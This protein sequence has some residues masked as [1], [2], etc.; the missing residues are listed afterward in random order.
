MFNSRSLKSAIIMA[1]IVILAV[2]GCRRTSDKSN[3]GKTVTPN[4]TDQTKE[5]NDTVA[6][7]VTDEKKHEI[8]PNG[9]LIITGIVRDQAGMPVDG[10]QMEIFPIRDW[11]LCRYAEGKFEANRQARSSS[12]SIRGNLFV[13][14]HA[15]RNLAA[16]VELD[17]NTSTLDVK[18]EPGVI[19]TGKVMD[20]DGNGIEK[21]R[22]A[23]SLQTS[24]QSGTL[25]SW[26]EVDAEGRF[27]FRAL[28]PEYGYLLS[29]RR[30]GY[31]VGRTE[32][33][34]DDVR[35]N[36]ID[37]VSIVLP[38]GKFSVSGIVVDANGKPVANALVYCTGKNQVGINSH[39]DADGKFKADGIFEGQVEVIANIK[40]DDGQWLG[41][42]I[43]TEAESTNL[44][45]V[46]GKNVMPPPK[47]R[48]C[49]PA[50][51]D[52]WVKGVVVPISKVARGQTVGEH[53]CAVP[54]AAFG[55]IEDI[56][57]HTGTF[58]CRDIVLDN[59]NRI[60]VVDA[61]CFML[62]S[63]RWIV[64]QDLRC[65]QRLKTFNGTVTIKSVTTRATPY[66]G[67]AFN[68]KIKDSDWYMVGKDSVIVRDY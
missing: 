53:G 49:F 22:V 35:D 30:I 4:K 31:R 20:G 40:G 42:S 18:L 34:S 17:E 37:A 68:L 5:S 48:T 21:A 7:D 57:E 58:E 63:G 15:Q 26:M 36:R 9:G 39:T 1:T 60:S 65:G 12:A 41:G 52:V 24:I 11:F 33:R 27:E 50:E 44:R 45:I 59:G 51:T 55:Q 23:I 62:D 47:G 66:V 29:A 6:K 38:R 14:R 43:S 8:Q 10:V 13:A 54:T 32:V 67:K 3:D 19:L 56:E 46:L 61:H 25:L 16:S 64:A 2:G 28:P